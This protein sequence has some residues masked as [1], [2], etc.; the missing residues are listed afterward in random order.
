MNTGREIETERLWLRPGANA[1]DNEPFLQ[2]LREDGDFRMFC[3]VDPEE[4]YLKNFVN[5]FEWTGHDECYYSIF[6]KEEPD[7]FI[8]Y[9]G[10]HREEHYEIEFYISKPYRNNG[11]CEEA[12]RAVIRLLFTEGLSVDGEVFTA[13]KLFATAIAGNAAAIRVLEKVGFRKNIPE[14]GP[15]FVMNV[16]V[17]K[18][19]DAFFDNCIEE[20]VLEKSAYFDGSKF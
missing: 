19:E 4:K 16:F 14:D 17:D 12:S 11:F 18:E 10:F 9:V 2:M 6:G 13:N 5:Y 20:Y 1:R 3:G 15:V 7:R 8:G